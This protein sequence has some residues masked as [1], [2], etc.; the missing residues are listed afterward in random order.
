VR[1]AALAGKR[2]GRSGGAVDTYRQVLEL[3]E[4]ERGGLGAL[5]RCAAQGHELQVATILQ[6]I[7]K[8]R[9]DWVKLVETYE[10]LVR[11]SMDPARQDRALHQIRRAVRG[12]GEDG[13]KAYRHLRSR[14]A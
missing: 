8:S 1:L 9:N 12:R 4:R 14:A 6:P 13:D 5:E 10:I 11:H 7:Y 2:A 3:H